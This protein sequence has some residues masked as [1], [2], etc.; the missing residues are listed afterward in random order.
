V[1]WAWIAGL[2]VLAGALAALMWA[3]CRAAAPP[4]EP[5]DEEHLRPYSHGVTVLRGGKRDDAA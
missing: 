2:L 1:I 3:L 4:D 5:P